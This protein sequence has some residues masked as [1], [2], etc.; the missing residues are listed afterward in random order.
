MEGM[1]G[2]GSG[3]QSGLHRRRRGRTTPSSGATSR[4]CRRIWTSSSRTREHAMQVQ[5][6]LPTSS[7]PLTSQP[8]RR[9]GRARR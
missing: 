4:G 5:L 6:K 7:T 2:E 8:R 9:G 3:E 1:D